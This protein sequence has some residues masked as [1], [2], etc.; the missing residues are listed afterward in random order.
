MASP[1]KAI[2]ILAIGLVCFS[3]LL[4]VFT[5][6]TWLML[7]GASLYGAF[8]AAVKLVSGFIAALVAAASFNVAWRRCVSA[9]SEG[10]GG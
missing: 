10:Q 2:A 4:A 7:G 9:L 8:I 5:A 1:R 3:L 6:Y